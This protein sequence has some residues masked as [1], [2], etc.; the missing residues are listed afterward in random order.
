MTIQELSEKFQEICLNH[1]EVKA[2]YVGN[3]WDQA[4]S[5]SSDAYP[6]VWMEFPVLITYDGKFKTYAFALDI[7]ALAKQDSVWNELKMQSQCEQISDQLMQVFKLK[8]ANVNFTSAGG[9]TVK[10]LNAD[11]ACGVR[12]DMQVATGR[13][14]LPLNNFVEEMNRL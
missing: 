10:N 9:L 2:F 1:K 6:C 4:A 13:E 14:C 5:K 11:I 8:I 3:T 12:I 7:L